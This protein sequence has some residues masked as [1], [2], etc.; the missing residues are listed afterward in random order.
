MPNIKRHVIDQD[1]D[2]IAAELKSMRRLWVGKGLD[3][4]LKR[5]DREAALVLGSRRAYQ[6]GE[7]IY[8]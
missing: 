7:L 8:A 4:L 1:L 3:G 2:A 6:P 5:R